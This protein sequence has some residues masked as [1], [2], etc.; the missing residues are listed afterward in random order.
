MTIEECEK[1]NKAVVRAWKEW[2]EG[3]NYL[4][5]LDCATKNLIMLCR[6]SLKRL[7]TISSGP[8][9]RIKVFMYCSVVPRYSA[10]FAQVKFFS[11]GEKLQHSPFLQG[12][13]EGSQFTM[14]WQFQHKFPSIATK[15]PFQTSAP[16]RQCHFP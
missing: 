13:T 5:N 14:C 8:W 15:P 4:E 6:Y 12:R 11:S 3:K 1:R 16:R 9:R 7:S 2:K 10:N